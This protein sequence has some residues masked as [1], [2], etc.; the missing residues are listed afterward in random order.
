M[1]NLS[2]NEV[3]DKFNISR[4]TLYRMIDEGL[5]YITV[6]SRKKVFDADTVEAFIE[7]RRNAVVSKLVLG[8]EYSNVEISE[9]FN[10]NLQRGMKKSNTANALVLLA[11]HETDNLYDD[12]WDENGIFYYTGMGFEGD[13]EL[14]FYEN[15]TQNK[16]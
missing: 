13:Q 8:Q 2:V 1:N 7:N 16:L 4:A 5:P 12:Y 15:K 6:G 14:D 10:A 9:I 3:T 11:K